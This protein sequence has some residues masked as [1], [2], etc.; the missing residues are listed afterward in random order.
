M[1]PEAD[2]EY[3]WRM[4]DV[5]QTYLWPYDPRYPVVCV[6]EACKQWFG[7]VRPAQRTRPRRPT[8]IDSA[9]ERKGVCHQRMRCEPLRGWRHVTVSERR[10]RRD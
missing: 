3:V 4:E 7:E 5:L 1:P 9:D 10:T 8:R 6:D 2:A